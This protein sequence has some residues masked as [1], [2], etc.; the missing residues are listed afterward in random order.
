MVQSGDETARRGNEKTTP[1]ETKRRRYANRK[2]TVCGFKGRG[3]VGARC[4]NHRHSTHLVE[5]RLRVKEHLCEPEPLLAEIL[6][7][8]IGELVQRL[9]Q[10]L[11]RLEVEPSR[12]D[13]LC[14]GLL[15]GLDDRVLGPEVP[16][17]GGVRGA[18]VSEDRPG[19]ETRFRR[20]IAFGDELSREEGE[21][22]G[23]CRRGVGEVV[24]QL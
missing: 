12:A 8:P 13:D 16:R 21:R 3:G 15:P 24:V 4:A 6:M 18:V 7:I 17:R 11:C 23:S 9:G 14:T 19:L 2:A 10:V 22:E 20:W 5:V 1:R